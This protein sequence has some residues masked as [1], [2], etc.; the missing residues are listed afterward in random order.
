MKNI[1]IDFDDLHYRH[2]ENCLQTIQYL[3][4]RND[5]IKLLFF[6]IPY[7]DRLEIGND[8]PFCKKL[9]K[10]IDSGHIQLAIHGT[11]HSSEEFKSLDYENARMKISLSERLMKEADL[12]FIK[13]FKGPHW[14]LNKSTIDVLMDRCYQAVFNHE[15]YKNLEVAGIDFK[16][17]NWNLK[18]DYVAPTDR[19][20]IAHGHT[21]NVC[22]N[23]I[24]EIADKLLMTLEENDLTPVHY[25]QAL[26]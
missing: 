6:T 19:L 15:D 24:Q 21:H 17:Y 20:V 7:L 5:K 4:D 25:D 23:G 18:D 26:A 14:G 2:P 12:P 8:D 11:Y 16:Y 1:I 3:V 22:G 13:V 9:R 10:Y